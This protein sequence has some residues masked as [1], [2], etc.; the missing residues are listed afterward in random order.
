MSNEQCR[1]DLAM[2]PYMILE[3]AEGSEIT[4]YGGIVQRSIG[5]IAYQN[6]QAFDSGTE[7][8]EYVW[9]LIHSVYG[10]VYDDEYVA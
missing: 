9:D 1:K 4:L 10:T 7:A 5:Y 6:R 2:R 8:Y 3:D